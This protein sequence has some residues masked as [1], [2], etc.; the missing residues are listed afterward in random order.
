MHNIL[1]IKLMNYKDFIIH[2]NFAGH[3]RDLLSPKGFM[4]LRSIH[5]HSKI[6]SFFITFEV[7][8]KH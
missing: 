8:N 5:M 1:F 7:R 6:G 3:T 4:N 2:L